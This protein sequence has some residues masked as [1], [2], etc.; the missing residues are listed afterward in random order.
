MSQ[1]QRWSPLSL[2]TT[3]KTKQNRGLKTKPTNQPT[4]QTN[5]QTNKIPK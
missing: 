2:K 1:T 3:N 5:K 4:N